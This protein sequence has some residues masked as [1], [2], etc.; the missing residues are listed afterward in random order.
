M[1]LDRLLSKWNIASRSQAQQL[2]REGSVRV[3]G[4]VERN[5]QLVV[6]P[7]RQLIEL[8][9][10][11]IREPEERARAYFVYNKPRGEVCTTADEHERRTVMAAFASVSIPGLAPVGRLD[12]ASAGLLLLTNDTHFADRLLDPRSHLQKRYRVKIHGRLSDED[13]SDLSNNTLEVDGLLLGPLQIEI[14][15]EAERSQWLTITLSEGKNR[16]IR[17]RL[18]ARGFEVEH[19]IRT[20][21]GPLELGALKPGTSRPLV[22]SE[23]SALEDALTRAART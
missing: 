7:T 2:V 13:L 16:Q 8:K 23:R 5:P 9:G 11:R 6:D 4:V 17:R 18:A 20:A 14:E 21:I 10:Q 15:S 19:L 22:R 1:R 12:R 3:D